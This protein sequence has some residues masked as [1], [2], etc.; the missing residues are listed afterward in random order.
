MSFYY[1]YLPQNNI[2]TITK[3]IRYPRKDYSYRYIEH[4]KK[5]SM[6]IVIRKKHLVLSPHNGPCLRIALCRLSDFP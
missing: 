2:F 6:D 4:I 5:H 1:L 3:V